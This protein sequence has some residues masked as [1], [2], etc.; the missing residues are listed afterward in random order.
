MPKVTKNSAPAK[1]EA[2]KPEAT[3]KGNVP[4]K[5]GGA[6]AKKA[7]PRS[8]PRRRKPRWLLPRKS[9]APTRASR[10]SPRAP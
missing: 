6:P 2:A 7:R 5:K 4:A 3:G 1:A 9:K 10:K 8:P